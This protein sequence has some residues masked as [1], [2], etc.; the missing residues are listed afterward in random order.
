VR[1]QQNEKIVC[2]VV[3]CSVCE[4]VIELQLIV[5]TI[6]QSPINSITHPNSVSNHITHDNIIQS[7]RLSATY[8]L[9]LVN[10]AWAVTFLE[11]TFYLKI[12]IK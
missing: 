11:Y 4:L 6:C 8:H 1:T 12:S 10:G 7:L 5:V 2:A 3:N 9:Q